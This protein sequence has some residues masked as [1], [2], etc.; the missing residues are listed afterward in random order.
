MSPWKETNDHI[1][2]GDGDLFQKQ[3][4]YSGHH[5]WY[6]ITGLHEP[7]EAL[8]RAADRLEN[9][10]SRHIQGTTMS[11]EPFNPWSAAELRS[12]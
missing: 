8:L 6:R 12:D 5:S 9:D 10:V 3:S 4:L 11:R 7:F 1:K 2:R